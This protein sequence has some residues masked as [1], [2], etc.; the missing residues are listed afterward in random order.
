VKILTDPL[1]WVTL[2][3]FSLVQTFFEPYSLNLQTEK[4]VT[5]F[6]KDLKETR[7]KFPPMSRVQRSIV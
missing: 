7:L 2:D 4:E 3:R 6:I 1:Q 5:E